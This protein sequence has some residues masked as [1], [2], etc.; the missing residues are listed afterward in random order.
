MSNNTESLKKIYL[1]NKLLKKLPDE[2]IF[3]IQKYT[4]SPQSKILLDSINKYPSNPTIIKTINMFL[5]FHYILN[6]H[7]KNMHSIDETS[8]KVKNA[9]LTDSYDTAMDWLSKDLL[10]QL[11]INEGANAELSRSFFKTL[12]YKKLIKHNGPTVHLFF[13]FMKEHGNSKTKII[14][15]W[16]FMTDEEIKMYL[17]LVKNKLKKA[18]RKI[19]NVNY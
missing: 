1:L 12:Q 10:K 15:L 16:E 2:I 5:K 17:D 11:N 19:S 3:L 4:Y 14:T 6:V 9:V 13:K 7:F 18:R 8:K